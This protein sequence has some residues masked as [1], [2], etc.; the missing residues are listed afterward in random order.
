MSTSSETLNQQAKMPFFLTDNTQGEVKGHLYFED[1]TLVIEFSNSQH[2]VRI[3]QPLGEKMIEFLDD[4]SI[5]V[6]SP[7]RPGAKANIFFHPDGKGRFMTYTIR[8]WTGIDGTEARAFRKADFLARF[9]SFG[10]KLAALWQLALP[11]VIFGA[12]FLIR[13]LLSEGTSPEADYFVDSWQW[14]ALSPVVAGHYVALLVPGLAILFLNRLWALQ[15]MFRAT[16]LLALIVAACYFLPE[17]WQLLPAAATPLTY[18]GYW[19]VFGPYLLL[20]LLP[21]FYYVVVMRRL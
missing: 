18:S 9:D 6:E 11:Y 15:L 17:T 12:T 13:S 2:V 7:D 10:A 14:L 5:R 8:D 1:D 20:L 16:I 4:S 19:I 3:P 21:A